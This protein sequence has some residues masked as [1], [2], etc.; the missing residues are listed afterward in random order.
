MSFITDNNIFNDFQKQFNNKTS[1]ENKENEIFNLI[2]EA[3]S[4]KKSLGR[5]DFIKEI[6][7]NSK[8]N[9]IELNKIIS[10]LKKELFKFHGVLTSKLP[11]EVIYEIVS[12]LDINDICTCDLL[13]K[14][15]HDI[16]PKILP[17]V[18]NQNDYIKNS[19]FIQSL[20][21]KNLHQFYKRNGLEVVD[22]SNRFFIN[23]ESLKEVGENSQTIKKLILNNIILYARYNEENSFYEKGT[24]LFLNTSTNEKKLLSELLKFF[25]KLETLE[26]REIPDYR[27]IKMDMILD[28]CS[29]HES[30]KTVVTAYY[31]VDICK[32]KEN[33][34]K[35]KKDIRFIKNFLTI[36][37]QLTNRSFNST[38]V[39]ISNIEEF[40][41]KKINN[42]SHVKLLVKPGSIRK[43]QNLGF[44]AFSKIRLTNSD[45]K[46]FK[47]F[48]KEM[49]ELFNL[50]QDF[51]EFD[52]REILCNDKKNIREI[53]NIFNSTDAKT[54]KLTFNI[55]PYHQELQLKATTL[56]RLFKTKFLSNVNSLE[57][58]S[59]TY[60]KL[61]QK[62]AIDFYTKNMRKVMSAMG[63]FSELET[64]H[65]C[66]THLFKEVN[67]LLTKLK[68]GAIFPNLKSLTILAVD[69]SKLDFQTLIAFHK[70]NPDLTIMI[71]RDA[72][73]EVPEVNGDYIGN[74]AE[75]IHVRK[76]I[77]EIF[78]NN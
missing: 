11:G 32:F 59:A 45:F 12:H 5:D 38:N 13:S 18:V 16:I 55:I 65:F 54:L 62:N 20:S 74:Y 73:I 64:L 36:S 1:D 7:K 44:T 67:L 75:T 6:K 21:N 47:E 15:F 26:I 40:C 77:E 58:S 52:L 66:G 8:E 28:S 9:V 68:D 24:G 23:W 53:I 78:K 22:Y 14:K 39:T 76:Q 70:Q 56:C 4:L 49:I 50:K 61:T 31:T 41:L 35:T 2:H 42:I 29:L 57:F 27:N 46:G 3:N 10:N 72:T 19:Q 63:E 60:S 48:E 33:F 37:N 25:P 30:L 43:I 51:V 71:V 69:Y 34:K 17:N